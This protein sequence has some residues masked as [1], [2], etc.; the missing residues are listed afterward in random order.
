MREMA[1]IIMTKYL[2]ISV[3][4]KYFVKTMKF[5]SEEFHKIMKKLHLL[6]ILVN[7]SLEFQLFRRPTR[8]VRTPGFLEL[9]LV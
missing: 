2:L 5:L 7:S 8:G 3:G 4:C 6:K 1:G 9:V